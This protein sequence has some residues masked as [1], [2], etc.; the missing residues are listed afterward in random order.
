MTDAKGR[1]SREP[2]HSIELEQAILA[3]L[4]DGR[5]PQAIHEV[6]EHIEH[7]LVFFKRNHQVAYQACLELDGE[8]E[9]V[10]AQSVAERLRQTPFHS[11]IDRL[12]EYAALADDNRLDGADATTRLR[13]ARRMKAPDDLVYEDSALAFIGGY[14]ELSSISGGFASFAGLGRNAALL[15]D[16]YNKRKLI[17]DFT[18]LVDHAFV[19]PDSYT[20]LLDRGNQMFLNLAS[21]G[22]Q[23]EV[24]DAAKT[25]ADTLAGIRERRRGDNLGI[26]TGFTPLDRHLMSLRPGG[27]YVLA[28]RPGVGKTSFAL[29]LVRNICTGSNPRP[30]LFYS[31]EVDRSDVGKKL[32]CSVG[33]LNFRSLDEGSLSEEEAIRMEEASEEISRWPLHMADQSDI[34]VMSLRGQVRRRMIEN[35]DIGM[36]II[37][38]LQL[39]SGSP[40][41]N[42]YEKISEI[43]RSLK[44]LARELRIPVLALSQLSRES[45]RGGKPRE[46]RLSD[47]RGSGSIEQDADAVLFLHRPASDSA[48]EDSVRNLK[49]LVEK[50]RFGPQGRFT[51]EFHPE[52]QHFQLPTS[53]PV[54]PRSSRQ[55]F[56]EEPSQE[57]DLFSV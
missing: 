5:R 23:T 25:M 20:D 30:I 36:V 12:R 24:A 37:D 6:S 8:R 16:Y 27:L 45:E 7:P 13:M 57:E 38:Y 43:S 39:L 53:T 42:E 26:K 52:R 31:L 1:I 28:A 40:G 50:N 19:T 15:R 41:L 18:R 2:P 44:V 21:Q 9:D 33:G 35:P 49:M 32:L 10:D 46:P 48:V 29:S 55:K 34:T 11:V 17:G 47:L 14:S 54:A 51:L 22:V 3:C 56:Q 4:L